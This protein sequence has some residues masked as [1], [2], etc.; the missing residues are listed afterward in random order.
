MNSNTRKMKN[1][2][3]DLKKNNYLMFYEFWYVFFFL[4]VSNRTV[5]NS[6]PYKTVQNRTKPYIFLIIKKVQTL[7]RTFWPPWM[8]LFKESLMC[9]F[10]PPLITQFF[11]HCINQLIPNKFLGSYLHWKML[12]SHTWHLVRVFRHVHCIQ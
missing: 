4:T 2:F 1:I 10:H 8:Y 11:T 6:W 9:R 7:H 12:V 3:S 5:F